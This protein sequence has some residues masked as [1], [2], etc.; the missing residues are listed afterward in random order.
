MTRR[1]ELR[2][3]VIDISGGLCEWPK[4][5]AAGME[6][7]HLHSV[8]AGGRKS[9]DTLSNVMWACRTHARV[10]DGEYGEG[11]RVQYVDAHNVLFGGMWPVEW[12]SRGCLGW[13]RAEALRLY[14]KRTRPI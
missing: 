3:R 1:Q 9:A 8:G 10:T 7:A 14:L 12:E 2:S 4:C 11:G 13:E 6:L 5:V